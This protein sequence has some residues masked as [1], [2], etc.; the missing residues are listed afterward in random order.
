MPDYVIQNVLS[1]Q[2]CEKSG[3]AV[4]FAFQDSRDC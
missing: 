2:R 3:A 4:E 1:D